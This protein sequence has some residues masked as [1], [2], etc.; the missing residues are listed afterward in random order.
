M[1]PSE[2]DRD[3]HLIGKIKNIQGVQTVG[4]SNRQGADQ[5]SKTCHKKGK[6]GIIGMNTWFRFYQ[7]AGRAKWNTVIIYMKL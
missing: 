2:F 4:Y 5:G 6:A 3:I 1:K 7:N